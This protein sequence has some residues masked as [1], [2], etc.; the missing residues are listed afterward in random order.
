MI[1]ST[2]STHPE[3]EAVQAIRKLRAMPG[4]CPEA[5]SLLDEA[6]RVQLQADGVDAE[7]ESNRLSD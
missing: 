6:L 4:N 7:Q 3:S 1:P 5:N 2:S